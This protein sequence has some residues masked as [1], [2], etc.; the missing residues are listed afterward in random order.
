MFN[1]GQKYSRC[2]HKIT[3]DSLQDLAGYAANMA[4]LLESQQLVN[5][6]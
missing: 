6:T 5:G 3:Y 2:A 1:L 4:A